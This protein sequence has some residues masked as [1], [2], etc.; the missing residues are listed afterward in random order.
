MVKGQN[1]Y[2]SLRKINKNGTK[3]TLFWILSKIRSIF[4]KIWPQKYFYDW[5]RTFLLAVLKILQ[6]YITY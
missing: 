3:D 2:L 5:Y 4:I 1:D 6:N